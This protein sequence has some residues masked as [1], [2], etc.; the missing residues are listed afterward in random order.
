MVRQFLLTAV[1]LSVLLAQNLT[2]RPVPLFGVKVSQTDRYQLSAG[3]KQLGDST[4]HLN[5]SS[6][7]PDVRIFHEAVRIALTYDEF[8]R[9]ED[10][11]KARELL[12]QGQERAEDLRN[13]RAP[14]NDA[15]GLVVRGYV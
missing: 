14:W 12:R 4:A 8:F 7:L 2:P 11:A 9:A 1:S 10:V 6:L 5:G 15:T 3:V 13:G